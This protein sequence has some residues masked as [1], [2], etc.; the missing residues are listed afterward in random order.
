MRSH[1]SL[2]KKK[3]DHKGENI[4]V[5][6]LIS[7]KLW[8]YFDKFKLRVASFNYEAASVFHNMDD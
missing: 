2:K 7:E 8:K 1:T 4:F 6:N 3:K 5:C